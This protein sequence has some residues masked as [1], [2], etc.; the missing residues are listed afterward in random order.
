M[1]ICLLIAIICLG[2]LVDS[3]G[4][5]AARS[6]RRQVRAGVQ[7]QQAGDFDGA[8]EAF[9][10]AA[11]Q[12]ADDPRIAYDQACALA[13]Q[14]KTAAASDLFQKAAL[15]RDPALAAASHYNLGCL[16]AQEAKAKFGDKPDAATPEVREQG[17]QLLQTAVMHY[18]DCLRV[19]PD[20]QAARKNLEV[21]RLW[22][23]H[24][25]DVWQ[26]RD[27]EKRRD[28][29]DLLTFLEWM[30]SEQRK[31]EL[32]TQTLAKLPPSPPQ[33]QAISQLSRGQRSLAEETD[34]L[35]RK[36]K[37]AL[38]APGQASPAPQP[39]AASQAAFDAVT[40]LVLRAKRAMFAA[41]DD[42]AVQALP[43]AQQSQAS[44]IEALNDVYRTVAPYEHLLQKATS[45][46]QQLVD[47]TAAAI[48]D[49]GNTGENADRKLLSRDQQ[50]VGGW[51][52]AFIARARAG[53]AQP[54]VATTS[55]PT[56]DQAAVERQAAREESFQRAIELGPQVVELARD[57]A[58]DLT[59]GNCQAAKPKQDKA[60]QLLKEIAPQ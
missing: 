34:P 27:R 4:W 29:M 50:F 15:A 13:G 60:L 54:A 45:V 19:D 6:A 30:Q 37:A 35:Q 48:A 52:E 59:D 10:K 25:Q 18:R 20:Y 12:L 31:L 8:A 16:A 23:K 51:A 21:L 28:E 58:K 7:K 57:A 24:M 43:P 42:L 53:L 47:T 33:R 46:E 36:L 1:R 56:P 14:G 3:T 26:R 5:A 38:A 41:A 39:T 55:Q 2:T 17:L 49:E 44:A 32:E 11:E 9:A 22:I 40:K